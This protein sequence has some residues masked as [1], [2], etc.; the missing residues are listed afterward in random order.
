MKYIHQQTF[1]KLNELL[2]SPP[3]LAFPNLNTP[4]ELHIDGSTHRL[5]TVLN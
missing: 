1:D 3:I 4:F 2:T 5:G